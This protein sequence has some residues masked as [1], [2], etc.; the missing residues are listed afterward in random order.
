MSSFSFF[1]GGRIVSKPLLNILGYFS[2]SHFRKN[3]D[4]KAIKDT[5]I[6]LISKENLKFC[7]IKKAIHPTKKDNIKCLIT[8]FIVIVVSLEKNIILAREANSTLT[9]K[10]VKITQFSKKSENEIFGLSIAN[11][12]D[13]KR[14]THLNHSKIVTFNNFI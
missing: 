3:S 2:E 12:G 14:V 1:E 8:S 5:I 7:P 10:N 13:I 4:R 11:K 6:N 9:I